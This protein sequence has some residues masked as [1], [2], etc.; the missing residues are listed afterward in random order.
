[1]GGAGW[2]VVFAGV[3]GEGFGEGCS[4]GRGRWRV[5]FLFLFS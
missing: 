5:S 4:G 2:G 1:M 3:G